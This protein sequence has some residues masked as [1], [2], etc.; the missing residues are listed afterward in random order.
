MENP[1]SYSSEIKRFCT[2]VRN[3]KARSTLTAVTTL[4]NFLYC[5]KCIYNLKQNKAITE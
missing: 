2:G 5:T 1:Y 4:L 3:L